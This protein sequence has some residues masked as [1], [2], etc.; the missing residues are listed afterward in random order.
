MQV[1]CGIK[2]VIHVLSNTVYCLNLLFV[3][4]DLSSVRLIVT[5]TNCRVTASDHITVLTRPT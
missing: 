3:G 5:I 2:T 1:M 4:F